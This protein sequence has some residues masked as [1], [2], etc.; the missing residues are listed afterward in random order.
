MAPA[1]LLPPVKLLSLLL[2]LPAAATQAPA[3]PPS[4]PLNH[5]RGALVP[6]VR[7][8]NVS[9]SM[10][11]P[12]ATSPFLGVVATEALCRAACEANPNCTQYN[13]VYCGAPGRL[14]HCYGRCKLAMGGKVFPTP[15]CTGLQ[16]TQALLVN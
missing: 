12:A 5:A 8:Q 7:A 3:Y 6:W 9:I 16:A 2:S 1:P 13:W 15:P 10:M 4:C 14:N 11:Q